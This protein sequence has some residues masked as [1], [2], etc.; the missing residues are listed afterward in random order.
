[1]MRDL[2]EAINLLKS[3]GLCFP[4]FRSSLIF[5]CK[6]ADIFFSVAILLL[7]LAVTSSEACFK[8]SA[9][10]RANKSLIPSSAIVKKV[11]LATLETP[12]KYFGRLITFEGLLLG[13]LTIRSPSLGNLTLF[14]V[15]FKFNDGNLGAVNVGAALGS[16]FA[17]K[18]ALNS[19]TASF[20]LFCRSITP[21]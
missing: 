17:L 13:L 21:P 1:M 9:L 14:L 3:T 16:V 18:A 11:G 6:A 8:S 15:F 4:F 19:A 5:F 2:V 10:V 7:A 12:F 20:C